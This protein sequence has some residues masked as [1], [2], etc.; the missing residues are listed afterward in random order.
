MHLVSLQ[1]SCESKYFYQLFGTKGTPRNHMD[2]S[3]PK[4]LEQIRSTVRGC[5]FTFQAILAHSVPPWLS[6]MYLHV[7]QLFSLCL[8]GLLQFNV[9]A[10][11]NLWR[12]QYICWC[13]TSH[14]KGKEKLP[15]STQREWFNFLQHLQFLLCLLNRLSSLLVNMFHYFQSIFFFHYIIQKCY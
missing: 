4:N 13:R 3:K 6:S 1:L 9:L 10:N 12:V 11:L 2:T 7:H 8:L 14:T 15:T 5:F